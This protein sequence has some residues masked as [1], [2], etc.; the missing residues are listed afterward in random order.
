MPPSPQS[1]RPG[2]ARLS[3]SR[4]RLLR[5]ER[6]Q[7]AT[8]TTTRDNFVRTMIISCFSFTEVAKR[9]AALMPAA[10]MT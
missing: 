2:I 4:H 10:M 6:A 1:R 3:R 9:A 5:Q 8:P 7:G